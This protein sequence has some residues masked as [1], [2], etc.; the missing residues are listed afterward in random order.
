MASQRCEVYCSCGKKKI[1]KDG[2]PDAKFICSR[3][4]RFIEIYRGSNGV[5]KTRP[6]MA[7]SI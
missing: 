2:K 4:D 1:F 6:I 7:A 3:C 5:L